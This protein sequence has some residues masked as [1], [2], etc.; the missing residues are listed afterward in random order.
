M[1]AYVRSAIIARDT[2]EEVANILTF[3]GVAVGAR[4][5]D[6]VERAGGQAVLEWAAER[7]KGASAAVGEGIDQP[8]SAPS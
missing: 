5:L 2:L 1:D 4:E 3:V 7:I 6:E 8:G